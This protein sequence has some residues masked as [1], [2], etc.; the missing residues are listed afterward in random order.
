MYCTYVYCM[1]VLSAYFLCT[2][3]V[4]CVYYCLC[5]VCADNFSR[6]LLEQQPGVDGSDYI[7]ASYVDVSHFI[8]FF[9]L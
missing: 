8:A 7:N 2:F 3:Y 5:I 4:L 1:T 6:V 9:I